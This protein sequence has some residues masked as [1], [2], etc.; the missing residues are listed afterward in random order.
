MKTSLV[1]CLLVAVPHLAGA[2]EATQTPV[3]GSAKP[4]S[5]KPTGW[6]SVG[7]GYNPDDGFLAGAAVGQDNLFG[8]GQRLVLDATL[9][10]IRQEASIAHVLPLG[11]GLELKSEL[12]VREKQYPGFR[13]QAQGGAVTLSH[14]VT[15]ATSVFARYQVEHVGI[16][17]A[18]DAVA[19]AEVPAMGTLGEGFL[20]TIGGGIAYDTLD[21][22]M[23][24]RHGT[25]LELA[26]ERSLGEA[27]T[28][29]RANAKLVH[30]RPVGPF[31]LRFS[32][33]ASYVRSDDPLGVPLAFRLQHDGHQ[34]VRGY[35]LAD[36]NLIGSNVEAL[37]RAELELPVWKRAG[38]SIAGFADAGYTRNTDHAWG[39]ADPALRRSVGLS[40]IWRS[41]IGP[42]TFDWAVPLDGETRDKQFLFSVGGSF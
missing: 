36:G 1:A 32:G 18:V 9:S 15:R 6:F 38:L 42:L 12:F 41:P 27:Y 28:M 5:K 40:I 22:Q 11:A 3:A 17:P 37:G 23:L 19:R 21:A 35:G 34:D 14:Q 16:Q 39:A 2:D 33:R 7:A 30:A 4:T 31:T 13:R 26:G 25:R 8:T 20:Q 10:T 29:I 24:P